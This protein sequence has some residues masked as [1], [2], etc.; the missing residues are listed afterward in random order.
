MQVT[1]P[2]APVTTAAQTASAKPASA[3]PAAFAS[4]LQQSRS[5]QAAP[6]EAGA[7]EA[8]AVAGSE[9]DSS[10]T[11]AAENT[12]FKPRLKPVDK[13]GPPRRAEHGTKASE[14]QAPTA[15]V[16]A[17]DKTESARA[18]RSDTPVADPALA[19]WLAVPHQPPP[20][21]AAAAREPATLETSTTPVADGK[22][23]DTLPG[24]VADDAASALQDKAAADM[25]ARL[26]TATASQQNLAPWATTARADKVAMQGAAQ[27]ALED[28]RNLKAAATDATAG[29]AALGAAA[30][31]PLLARARESAPPLSVN[32]PTPLTS[33]EFAQALGVQMSVLASDGVQ[34]AELHLNPAEMGPVSVQ[35]V[36]DGSSARVDFGADLAATRH[37][38]E[39]GLPELAGALRDAGFT[40]AGGG[41]SQHAG[42]RSGS[43]ETPA[44]S[45]NGSRRV[46]E[47]GSSPVQ[48]AP[49]RRA[50]AAGG[51][52]LYA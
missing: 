42:G 2:A 7:P 14:G 22:A 38:I 46:D 40:L 12:A 29:A 6:P 47:A 19:A 44:D 41:V 26:E 10:D 5:A 24:T 25:Q 43:R 34:R 37:A 51:V 49:Q 18:K 31:N 17:D 32:L 23:A 35:I 27:P 13:A 45:G 21:E 33:P 52:D 9:A 15:A 20:G 11:P 8:D 30:F 36:I 3:G 39:A 16:S 4:L 50:V 48:A 28:T 1:A